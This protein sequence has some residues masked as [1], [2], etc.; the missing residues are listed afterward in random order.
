M[1]MAT[2][3]LRFDPGTQ[4]R[5]A[6]EEVEADLCLYV[7]D[8]IELLERTPG[9]P[10]T[11]VRIVHRVDVL[12]IVE[13]AKPTVVVHL[14]RAVTADQVDELVEEVRT[15]LDSPAITGLSVRGDG[16]VLSSPAG[17]DLIARLDEAVERT[18]AALE[19]ITSRGDAHRQTPYRPTG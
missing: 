11:V 14:L 10:T 18:D 5:P 2:F 7:G 4:A 16:I 1:R 8:W 3:R 15:L 9:R 19:V 6:T 12:R 13:V 17:A